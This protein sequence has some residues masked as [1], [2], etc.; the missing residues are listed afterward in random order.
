MKIIKKSVAVAMGALMVGS[1]L[2]G[3][4]QATVFG[5]YPNDYSW[6]YKD[7]TSTLSIGSQIEI[8]L[9]QLDSDE[10]APVLDCHVTL[11]ADAAKW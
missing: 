1:A 4:I 10:L 6:S 11:R 7:E 2:S 5:S 9:F 3:C 8:A